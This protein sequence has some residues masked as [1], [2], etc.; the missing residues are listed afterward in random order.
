V[1]EPDPFDPDDR[2]KPDAPRPVIA[3][4]DWIVGSDDGFVTEPGA[5]P[6]LPPAPIEAPRLVRPVDPAAG[7]PSGIIRSPLPFRAPP[8]APSVPVEPA[9]TMP[10]WSPGASS[11][12]KVRRS[13]DAAVPDVGP[14]PELAREFPMDDAEERARVS[15]QVAEQQAREAAVAARPHEIVRPQDFE[16]PALELPWW[17][18]L[19]DLLK[20]DKRLQLAGLLLVLAISLLAFWPRAEKTISVAHLKEHPEAYADQPVRV[21]GR[22]S[23]VFPVGGSVAYTLVQGRDTIVVFSRSRNPKPREHVIVVGTLSTGYLGG[24]TRTAIFEATR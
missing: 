10:S 13:G 5:I 24:E 7:T 21:G 18:R 17:S 15:A 11:V 22:V 2:P 4:A 14:I 19:P 23:E 6:A 8:A 9:P 1:G 16:L 20:M 12:P 3:R